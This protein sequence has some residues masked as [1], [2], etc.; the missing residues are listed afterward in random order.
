M[1]AE[2]TIADRMIGSLPTVLTLISCG[3]Q[4]GGDTTINVSR[5]GRSLAIPP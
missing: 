4:A 3:A 5:N 2:R 1:K